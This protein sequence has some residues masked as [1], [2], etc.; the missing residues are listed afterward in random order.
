MALGRV[1]AVL[2]DA[3]GTLVG[4]DPPAPRLRAALAA[5][6]VDVSEERAA[7]A[8]AAEIAY[9]LE[10]QL[11]GRDAAGLDELRD[12]CADVLREALGV[13]ELDHGA[14]RA[15]MLAAIRFTPYPDARPALLELRERGLRLV[16]A[17]NWDCSLPGA[18]RDAGLLE[19]LDGV[20]SSAEVG[21][22]KPD[23]RLFARALELAGCPPERALHVGDSMSGDVAGAAA[24]GIRAVLLRRGGERLDAVP[25]DAAGGP[26]PGA[27]IE[28]LAELPRVI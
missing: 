4:M 15:A 26:A 22:R 11:D 6:G 27:T 25:A 14:A 28:S 19:L 9:Y 8:F 18:L 13:P 5:R 3:F 21:A 17:S 23:A 24:A 16:V 2:L 20:V 12:R 7:D 1:E 10:H